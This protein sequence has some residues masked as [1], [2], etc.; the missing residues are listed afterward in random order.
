M[1]INSRTYKG[2]NYVLFADLPT[3]Q[4]EKFNVANSSLFIKIMIDNR[5]VSKCIQYKDY[6]L[7]FDTVYKQPVHGHL[8]G[9]PSQKIELKQV[10]A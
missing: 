5:V 10:E 3:A 4:Q 1:K 7:W 2:I 8:A 9:Q 6:E